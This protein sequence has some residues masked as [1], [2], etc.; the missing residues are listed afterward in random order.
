MIIEDNAHKVLNF[1]STI[2]GKVFKYGSS[3]FLR[4]AKTTTNDT[5]TGYINAVNLETGKPECFTSNDVIEP[6]ENAK[7]V[8]E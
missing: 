7:V 2:I 4:I 8:I 6:I 3:Y 1:S 5:D